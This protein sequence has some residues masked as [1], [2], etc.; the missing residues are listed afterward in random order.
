M[1]ANTSKGRNLNEEIAFINDW[2]STIIEF[3]AQ[4]YPSEFW[5]SLLKVL[6]T[7]PEFASRITKSE[8]ASGYRQMYRDINEMSKSLTKEHT[9]A[10][11]V[12]LKHKFGK[13][14]ADA[15]G[16]TDRMIKSIL[17]RAVIRNDEEYEIIEAKVDELCQM[18]LVPEFINELNRL[19]ANY[20]P[21]TK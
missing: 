9:V 7:E 4:H 16:Q 17:K 21:F 19:L 20:K 12:V 11:N 6:Q 14:L 5:D 8:L 18:E 10:L 1:A 3:C 15:S 2:C 13:T